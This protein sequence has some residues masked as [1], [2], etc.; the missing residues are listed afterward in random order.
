MKFIIQITPDLYS[1]VFSEMALLSSQLNR[2]H[3]YSQN[4]VAFRHDIND[5]PIETIQAPC[6]V[7]I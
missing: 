7:K 6:Y 4:F 5:P 1:L 2:R 3:C